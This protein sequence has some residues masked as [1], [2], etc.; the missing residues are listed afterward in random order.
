MLPSACVVHAQLEE[1]LN[2]ARHQLGI[3]DEEKA[4]LR[5]QLAEKDALIARER[6]QA[7]VREAALQ[8]RSALCPLASAAR[9]ERLARLC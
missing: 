7:H 2:T 5:T 4:R 6:Q 3:Q 9:H 8:V 1:C